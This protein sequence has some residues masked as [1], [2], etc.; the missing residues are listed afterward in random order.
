MPITRGFDTI[1]EDLGDLIDMYSLE[2][3]RIQFKRRHGR[4]QLK[5]VMDDIVKVIETLKFRRRVLHTINEKSGNCRARQTAKEIAER[6]IMAARR[7]LD[8]LSSI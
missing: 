4:P 6:G 3:E 7:S 5:S 1:V 2:W 8:A